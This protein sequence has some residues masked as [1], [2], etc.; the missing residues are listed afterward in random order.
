M[1]AKSRQICARGEDA[2]T[3]ASYRT[4]TSNLVHDARIV[5]SG[6]FG[7]SRRCMF[8]LYARLIPLSKGAFHAE[9]FIWNDGDGQE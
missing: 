1:T 8:N 2:T 9:I 3:V 5:V 6:S 4:P 7:V